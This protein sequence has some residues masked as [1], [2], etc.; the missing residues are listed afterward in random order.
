MIDPGVSLSPWRFGLRP[1]KKELAASKIVRERI[2]ACASKADLIVIS[3]YHF[4]HCTPGIKRRFEWTNEARATQ[5]YGGKL[6]YAK[7]TEAFINPSQKRRAYHLWKRGD[8]Q[9]APAD[10][11]RFKNVSFSHPLFHG[12]ENSPRGWVIATLIEE[13][14]ERFV[15]ASDIQ[16][17]HTKSVEYVLSLCPTILLISGPPLYLDELDP[18][19]AQMGRENLQTLVREAPMV[20]LDHH[21]LR[22]QE[23]LRLMDELRQEAEKVGHKVLCAA[24]YMGRP[25]LLLEAQRKELHAKDPVDALWYQRLYNEDKRVMAEVEALAA[26]LAC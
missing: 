22:S 4:D 21:I 15:H 23:A 20:I 18:K 13:G 24:E 7:S 11:A 10:G 5:L 17:L 12:E 26:E 19:L 2:L 3:H 8:C 1:H 6:I 9:I 25:P 14:A 16:C